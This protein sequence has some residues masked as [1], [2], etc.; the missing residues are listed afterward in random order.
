MLFRL[1]A[2]VAGGLGLL[3]LVLAVVG[4]YGVVSYTVGQRR[5]E[6]AIRMAIGATERDIF[7]VLVASG[8][9]LSALTLERFFAAHI[10]ML[11]ALL[12]GLI[13]V[14]LFLIIK[15]GESQFPDKED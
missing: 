1:G 4:L 5:H 14:H 11:P 10:W 3:A 8:S 2:A 15:H 9:D 7:G 12:A 13:G 6:I